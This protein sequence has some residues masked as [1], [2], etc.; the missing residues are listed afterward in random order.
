[1]PWPSSSRV[2]AIATLASRQNCQQERGAPRLN[3]QNAEQQRLTTHTAIN[4]VFKSAA[5]DF[6]L[7]R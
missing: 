5:I 3:S 6:G 2:A 7:P 4:I 1:M